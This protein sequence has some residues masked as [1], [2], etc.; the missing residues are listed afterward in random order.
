MGRPSRTTNIRSTDPTPNPHAEATTPTATLTNPPGAEPTVPTPQPTLTPLVGTSSAPTLP[1][2]GTTT[3]IPRAVTAAPTPTPGDTPLLMCKEDDRA[4]QKLFE[5]LKPL[6]DRVLSPAEWARWCRELQK[7]TTGLSNWAY[8]R[9]KSDSPQQGWAR[10]QAQRG[11]RG[12]EWEATQPGRNRTITRMANLQRNY[13]RSPQKCMEAIRHTPPPPRCEVPIEVVSEYYK[14]KLAAPRGIEVNRKIPPAWKIS[15]T[16][17]IHKGDDPLALD[18]WRPIALQ[19]TL[20]K[21]YAAIIARR[22]SN[23]AVETGVMS[24]A[25]KG[26]LPMEGC[27]EHNHLMTSVLQDSRRRKR[28]AYLAWLDLKDAYGSVPHEILFKTM[29][30]AGLVGSTLEVVKDFYSCTTTAVCTKTSSTAPITIERGVKQG[31]P[32]SPILFNVVMEVLIRAAEGVPRA[33]YRVANSVI[34]S[35]AY[36]DDLCVLASTPELLQQI[37]DRL[38]QASSW[39]G[40]AFSPRKCATLAIVRAYRARQRVAD[41][42]FRLGGAVVPKMDWADRYKYLGVKTGAEHSPDLTRV[43]GEYTRD[44]ELITTSE[45]TDWQKLDAIHRFAKPRLVYLLQNQLPT[46]G[47]AR[48]LDKKVKTLVK[49]NLRL[50]KR[51]TDA[52]MFSPTRAGGLGLPRIEDE[53]HIYGV[54][55]AYRL[56]VTSKDPLVRDTALAALGDSARKR[57][58]GTRTPEEFLNSPPENGEGQ[59]GNIKSLWSRVRRSLQICQASLGLASRLLSIAGTDACDSE[60]S[61]IKAVKKHQKDVHGPI[62]PPTTSNGAY[63]CSYCPMRFPSKTSLSQHVRGKHMEEASQARAATAASEANGGRKPWDAVEIDLFK[64]ALLQV[65]PNSNVEI[66]KIVGTRDNKQVGVF[67]CSFLA[68]NPDW[69]ANNQPSAPRAL[70]EQS[71]GHSVLNLNLPAVLSSSPPRPVNVCPPIDIDIQSSF[72]LN[73]SPSSP[74]PHLNVSH[75]TPLNSPDVLSA[76]VHLPSSSPAPHPLPDELPTNALEPCLLSPQCMSSAIPTIPVMPP[77]SQLH[78]AYTDAIVTP[79]SSGAPV[80]CPRSPQR[81]L[82][83]TAQ[84]FVPA[85]PDAYSPSKL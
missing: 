79:L 43:G 14:T 62:E 37:L 45:L 39:A 20:Y 68:K 32:L 48:A 19:N 3:P 70:V 1:A 47:W 67:K 85:L 24:P 30:M 7:W 53:V 84:P 58:K 15:S 13:N 63:P 9:A 17:L 29:E 2:R 21:T 4:P 8:A 6:T 18:N 46:L 81:T 52:F 42:E 65:G 33:G 74:P 35:L 26:F 28:P 76:V 80:D 10:R 57:S 59:Q 75:L 66:A 56:L 72:S 50:P 5:T 16:I 78:A 77:P 25:Q 69:L 23:W 31:C 36:A 54:S 60:F 64:S 27:L 22:V 40:L 12:G 38:Q 71:A 61:T 55:T 51:T 73:A 34:K 11:N 83:V 82:S 49:A 41:E 44:V